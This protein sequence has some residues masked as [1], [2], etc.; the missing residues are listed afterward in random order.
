MN[1]DERAKLRGEYSK[2]KHAYYNDRPKNRTY[3]CLD[4]EIEMSVPVEQWDNVA[5]GRIRCSNPRCPGQ[6]RG[7]GKYKRV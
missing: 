3:K 6:K 2:R 7:G 1:Q 5:S 4:C